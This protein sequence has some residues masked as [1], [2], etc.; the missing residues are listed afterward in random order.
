VTVIYS[1]HYMEEAS[2]LCCR[3]GII[4]HGK[5]LALGNLEQLLGSLSFQDEIR[6][7]AGA[8]TANLCAELCAWGE[9]ATADGLHR[10]RPRAGFPLSL[11]YQATERHALPSRLFASQRPTLEAVFLQFTGKQ[12]RE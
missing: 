8:E 5:I 12:L 3:I 2:R 10:F 11:F 1:T 6:F 9:L 7:P 4:D